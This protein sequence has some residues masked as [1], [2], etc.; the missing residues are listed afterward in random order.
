MTTLTLGEIA[1][2]FGLELRGD[3]A[4]EIRGVATLAEAGPGQL[5][6]LANPRYRAQ[7]AS[8]R[9]GAI[10]LRAGDADAFRGAAL[11]APDPYVAFARIATVYERMPAAA[12]GAH[13]SAVVADGARVAASASIGP[14]PHRRSCRTS[15]W[16]GGFVMGGTF[17]G[18]G[19]R[20]VSEA[21]THVGR[22][23]T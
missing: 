21:S 11:V 19:Q 23:R 22:R 20:L 13:A 5:G 3:A 12:P 14:P 4:T 1:A 8:T 6:F 2:R 7:L 18:P 10:V 15:L 9:A 17:N 16:N